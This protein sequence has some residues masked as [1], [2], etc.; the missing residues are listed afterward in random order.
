MI[1]IYTHDQSQIAKK[2]R[3]STKVKSANARFKDQITEID[4][5]LTVERYKRRCLY[6]GDCL[7]PGSWQLDHFYSR[8]LGGKNVPENLA[9][10]CK[11]CNISKGALD[12][13][14]YLLKCKKVAENYLLKDFI[15]DYK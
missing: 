12:G 3:C 6:C 15:P 14:A 9:P 11:W 10:S 2:F 5:V 8:K 7:K 1:I 13:H 4:V